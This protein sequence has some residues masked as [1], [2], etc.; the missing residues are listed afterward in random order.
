MI[1]WLEEV[2]R[3]AQSEEERNRLLELLGQVTVGASA[4]KTFAAEGETP[5]QR[6]ET[7]NAPLSGEMG[8]LSM[9]SE[10]HPL[11]LF[12]GSPAWDSGLKQWSATAV[13]RLAPV[14]RM[15]AEEVPVSR[16]NPEQSPLETLS[17]VG[18]SG[19][20]ASALP[21]RLR[22]VM[23]GGVLM[24]MAQRAMGHTLPEQSVM[25]AGEAFA[26]SRG[27]SDGGQS[28]LHSL[29]RRM[30]E[31]VVGAG[32]NPTSISPVVIR[33]EQVVTAGLTARELDRAVRRDSR[34]YDGGMNIY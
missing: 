8:S 17:E 6:E 21:S 24:T 31:A 30:A 15:Q 25:G 29:Y 20:E 10:A 34:R 3:T 9:G 7:R 14:S 26:D 11:S 28:V 5:D 1:D 13:E 32:Q 18:L 23:G 12:S 33:E 27:A 22:E 19:E 2:L 16:R 4:R